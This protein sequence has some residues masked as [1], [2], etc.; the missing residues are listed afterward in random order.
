MFALE[1]EK[2]IIDYYSN[3]LVSLIDVSKKYNCNPVTIY[4]TLKNIILN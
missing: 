1:Q 3:N 4:N 2:E